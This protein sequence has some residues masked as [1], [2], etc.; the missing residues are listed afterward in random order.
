MNIDYSMAS[1]NMAHVYGNITSFVTEYMKQLFPDKFKTIHVNTTIA[2][3]NFSRF[4]NTN[5]EFI[6]KRKPMML[7]RPRLELDNRDAF[8]AGTLFT[9]RKTDVVNARE[10]GNLQE[11]FVDK[12][13]GLYI[14]FLMNRLIMD[15]DISLIFET[16]MQQLNYLHYFKNRIRQEAPFVVTTNLESMITRDMIVLLSDLADIDMIDGDQI[17]APR[18]LEY[19]NKHSLYPVTYKMKNSTG[20]DEFFRYHPAG[21]ELTITGLSVDDGQ[22]SGQTTDDYGINFTVRAEFSTAGMYYLFSGKRSIDDKYRYLT[23]D[24]ELVNSSIF[25]LFTSKNLFVQHIPEGWQ[26]YMCPTFF[27][28][29]TDPKPFVLSVEQI[30]NNSIQAC[31]DYH[32]QYNLPFDIFLN[33]K[34]LKDNRVMDITRKEYELICEDE[35]SIKIYNWNS[36]STYRLLV[37]VNTGYINNLVSEI[38]DINKEK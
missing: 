25:P 6:K 7:I 20:R 16:Q 18:I 36:S 8:L 24:S 32:K 1:P 26:L 38:C 12:E 21:V 3:R 15:Y 37:S 30:F 31:V 29:P 19:M 28:D 10:W 23:H 4:N 5:K 13:K 27:I 2:Y 9:E 14:K 33:V 17:D 22:K 11:F 35:L 34:C